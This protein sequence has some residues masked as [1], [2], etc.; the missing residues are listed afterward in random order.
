MFRVLFLMLLV[1]AGLI[2]APYMAGSQ[3]YVRIETGSKIFEMSLVMLIVFFAISMATVYLLEWVVTRFFRL[4]RGSYQWFG[5][6]KRKLAQKQTLEGLMKMTEGDYSKAEKLISKNAMHSDEPVLNFIKAAEAAQQRGDDLAANKHLLEA[7]K[8]AGP[9]SIAVEIA[10]TRILLQQG[11]LPA[12]RSSVDSL[13]VLAP[14][15]IDALRLAI[16]IYQK[17]KAYKALDNVLD[18]IGKRS[19]LSAE[20][21]ESLEHQ[22]EDGLLDEIM[23]DD[24]QE[25]LLTWWDNQP[26]N[27][28]RSVYLRTALIK[29]LLD[30]NDHQSAAEIALETVKKADDEQLQPL[31]KELTRLQVDEHSKLLKV[32]AKR[33]NKAAEHYQD[34]Y[35]RA[36]GY[37]YAREGLFAQAKGYFVQV[38]EHK[39]CTANDRIMA[40]Y[41]AEQTNDTELVARIRQDNLKEVNVSVNEEPVLSLPEDVESKA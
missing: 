13:L 27:R 6:R 1:L 30:T 28:R 35:A 19:F 23:N 16:E 2:L 11:K 21:Y 20:E 26:S 12:A 18:V 29:R 9:N 3:G 31:F 15:N 25:G 5:N 7:S 34:D 41:V 39:E 10:R 24:G 4:S 22:V 40:L 33:Y 38:L 8:I 14:N 36:L 32:L 37:I 17:S